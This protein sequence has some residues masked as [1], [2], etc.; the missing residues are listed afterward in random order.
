MRGIWGENQIGV[1]ERDGLAL[2]LFVYEAFKPALS[3]LR[4]RPCNFDPVISCL[5]LGLCRLA[6]SHFRVIFN[7]ILQHLYYTH[8][9]SSK[10]LNG[11]GGSLRK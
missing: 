9:L 4:F 10:N 1:G 8:L 5:C 2:S 6:V 3:T 11:R 7:R